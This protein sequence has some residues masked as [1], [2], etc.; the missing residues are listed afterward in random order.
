MSL[1]HGGASHLKALRPKA[2]L[3]APVLLLFMLLLLFFFFIFIIIFNV[4]IIIVCSSFLCTGLFSKKLPLLLFL[5][6]LALLQDQLVFDVSS[7]PL[8]RLHTHKETQRGGGKVKLRC[9]QTTTRGPYAA[10]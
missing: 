7:L 4:I 10:R 8:G 5:Q 6:F 3:M 9:G 1:T 2:R